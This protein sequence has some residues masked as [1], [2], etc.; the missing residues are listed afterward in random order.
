MDFI[1][2]TLNSYL[3]FGYYLMKITGYSVYVTNFEEVF[4]RFL[5]FFFK[6]KINTSKTYRFFFCGS[7]ALK[8][9]IAALLTNFKNCQK[10]LSLARS[11]GL[12]G[13]YLKVFNKMLIKL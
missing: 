13:T 7:S 8:G 10:N 5:L 9:L 1:M 4:G 12:T 6:I 11:F 3:P 2:F